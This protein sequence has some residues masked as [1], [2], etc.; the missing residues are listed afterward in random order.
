MLSRELDALA[1]LL[2]PHCRNGVL[3]EA[4]VVAS[5]VAIFQAFALH[6]RVLEQIAIPAA[7]PRDPG[8]LPANVVRF[9]KQGAPR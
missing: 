9:E 3:I 4:K 6:A 5:L 2:T 1:E 8:Q 7:P